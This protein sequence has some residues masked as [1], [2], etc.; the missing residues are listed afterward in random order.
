MSSFPT[1]Q[2]PLAA[3]VGTGVKRCAASVGEPGWSSG[4][5]PHL[6]LWLLWGL[7][8]RTASS[9]SGFCFKLLVLTSLMT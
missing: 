1:V 4:A 2:N 8:V 5:F 6:C 7:W 9:S 3:L